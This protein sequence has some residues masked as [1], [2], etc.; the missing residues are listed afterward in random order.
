MGNSESEYSLRIL[1][2]KPNSPSSGIPIEPMLDFLLYPPAKDGSSNL[3]FDKY[4][5]SNEDKEIEL[6]YY[7]IASQEMWKHKITPKKWEGEGLL[8]VTLHPEPYETAHNKVIH[9]LDVLVGS[10]MHKAGF[11]PYTDYILGTPT[12]IFEDVADFTNFIQTNDKKPI[13]LVVYSTEDEKSR[14]LT[15]VPDSTW[16]GAGSL[17]GEIGFGHVH[18]LPLKKSKAQEIK[19][20]EKEKQKEELTKDEPKESTENAVEKD[21]TKEVAKTEIKEEIKTAEHEKSAEISGVD[22]DDIILGNKG[23][24][25]NDGKTES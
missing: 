21:S 25:V 9:I 17:G 12:V 20:M 8:G 11:K 22:E 23:T 19:E 15:L 18:S 13:D 7:N 14:V 24:S 16:G 4:I 3:S 1:K 6:T 10:P 5:T 2:V